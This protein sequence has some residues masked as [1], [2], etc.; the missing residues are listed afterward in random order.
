MKP[1]GPTTLAMLFAGSTAL[2]SH[3]HITVDTQ[4]TVD[5]PQVVIRAG[6]LPNETAMTIVDGRLFRDGEIAVY[7]SIDPL[8]QSGPLSG[9]PAGFELV[10]TSDYYFSSG[11]LTGGNFMWE[12][13]S[14]APV[15]GDDAI[16]AWGEFDDFGTFNDTARSDAV[17]RPARSYN[18]F[19]G[20]HEHMQG[21]ALS[22]P[23]LYDVTFIAWDSNGVYLDSEPVTIRFDSR[24]GSCVPDFNDDGFADAIDYDLFIALWLAPDDRADVNH[25]G[26]VDAIDFD[27]FIAAWLSGGC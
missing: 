24:P 14:V 12:I 5:G 27:I 21:C 26:F 1:L 9:W 4:S 7:N 10:L 2:G 22:S 20:G 25:D 18:T 11:R 13:V 6:Y 8:P 23:G 19:I 17:T 15:A 3:N 16:L